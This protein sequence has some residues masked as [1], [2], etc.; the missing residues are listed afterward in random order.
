MLLRISKFGLGVVYLSLEGANYIG[1][2]GGDVKNLSGAGISLSLSLSN[3]ELNLF[4]FL[5]A[6]SSIYLF[7]FLP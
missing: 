7:V 3:N 4:H 6:S 2:V 5:R 1:V